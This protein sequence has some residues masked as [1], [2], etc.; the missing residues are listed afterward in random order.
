L[1]SNRERNS[2]FADF[3]GKYVPAPAPRLSRTPAVADN[4]PQPVVGGCTRQVLLEYGFS[5][6]EISDLIAQGAIREAS[7]QNKL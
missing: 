1:L 6:K 7:S 2:F 5:Q 3:D 4:G